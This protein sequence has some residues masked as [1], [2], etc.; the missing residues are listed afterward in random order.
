[1]SMSEIAITKK[2]C[3]GWCEKHRGEVRPVECWKPGDK[4]PWQ[5]NYCDEAIAEDTRNGFRVVE[6]NNERVGAGAL[7]VGVLSAF[8]M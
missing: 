4:I 2:T 7:K 5:F 3:E 8:G 6:V 1:M